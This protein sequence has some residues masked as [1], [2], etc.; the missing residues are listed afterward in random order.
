MQ[1]AFWKAAHVVLIGAVVACLLMLAVFLTIVGLTIAEGRGELSVRAATGAVVSITL[2]WMLGHAAR[3]ARHR[4]TD[5][6]IARCAAAML[7]EHEQ[8][9]DTS[10]FQATDTAD[11]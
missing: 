1:I 6:A 11:R 3:H 7:A 10:G 4:T 9:A 2:I 8:A 5:L